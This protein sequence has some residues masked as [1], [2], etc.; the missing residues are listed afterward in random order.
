MCVLQ[1]VME[2]QHMVITPQQNTELNG[3]GY[4]APWTLKRNLLQLW[5][6][7]YDLP[8]FPTFNE[9]MKLREDHPDVFDKHFE[10]VPYSLNQIF[11]KVPGHIMNFVVE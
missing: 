3:Y 5:A 1:G 10:L 6:Q 9:V 2:W 11:H 7:V 4:D 8:Y